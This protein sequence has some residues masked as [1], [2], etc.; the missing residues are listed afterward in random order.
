MKKMKF[1]GLKILAGVSVVATPFSALFVTSCSQEA[2][3]TLDS[4]DIGLINFSSEAPVKN[5]DFTAQISSKDPNKK[6]VW[7]NN[8][9][10]GDS[11]LSY[12]QFEYSAKSGKLTIPAKYMMG[13]VTIQMSIYAPHNFATDSWENVIIAANQGINGLINLYYPEEPNHSFVGATRTVEVNSFTPK[14]ITTDVVKGTYIVRVIGQEEDDL[15][16]NAGKAPLTFEFVNLLTLWVEKDKKYQCYENTYNDNGI[17]LN[18]WATA[19]GLSCLLRSDLAEDT[20]DSL[21]NNFHDECLTKGIKKVKKVTS[22]G[23]GSKETDVWAESIFCL[24][25][26]EMGFKN[27]Y[28]TEGKVYKYYKKHPLD[29]VKSSLTGGLNDYWLRST[30]ENNYASSI[31]SKGALIKNSNVSS[32]RL[33]ICPVFCI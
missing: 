11:N 6:Y 28:C 7:I 30:N 14:S 8:I 16:N 12:K 10:I 20:K 21:L 4:N 17:Y 27:T 32:D 25:A 24:S 29:R 23:R 13:D 3:L 1:L 19:T 2:K 31:N 15:V 18:T 9:R 22:K 26:T 5:K 33:G